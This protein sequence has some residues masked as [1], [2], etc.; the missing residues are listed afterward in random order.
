MHSPAALLGGTGGLLIQLLLRA[1][2][3]GAVSTTQYTPTSFPKHA[4]AQSPPHLGP[5]QIVNSQI[6]GHLHP[7][8]VKHFSV[9][10]HFT[11]R[12]GAKGE[13]VVKIKVAMGGTE[14]WCDRV[15]REMARRGNKGLGKRFQA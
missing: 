8:V 5:R 1:S 7:A 11:Q 15:E 9:E 4:A 6:V 2:L 13:E 14:G 12:E 10:I 3:R